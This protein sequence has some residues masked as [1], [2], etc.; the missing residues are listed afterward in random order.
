MQEEQ[1]IKRIN[2]LWREVLK[3]NDI[4]AIAIKSIAIKEL[5]ILLNRKELIIEVP[6]APNNLKDEIKK[7]V[8]EELKKYKE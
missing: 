3:S 4:E 8:V 2:L 7:E 6:N 5:Y 1:V